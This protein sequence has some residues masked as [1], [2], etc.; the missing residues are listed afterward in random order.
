AAD[1]AG[2]EGT[3]RYRDGSRSG[4]TLTAGDWRGGPLATKAVALPHL[5]TRRDGQLAEKARLYAVTV[6]LERGRTVA[7]V[8][9]PR[10]PGADADLHVFDLAVRPE[11][12]GWTGSWSAGTGG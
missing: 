5:N 3:V 12:T 1:A 7:S 4:Y 6:P 10:D 8:T 2:G 9:L 11:A